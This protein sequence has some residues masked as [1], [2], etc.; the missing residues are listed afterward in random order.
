MARK[1][2]VSKGY[3]KQTT[4]KPYLSKRDIIVLCVLVAAVAVGA[5]FLFR[6]DDGAL[7]VKDGAVVAGGDNWL[8]VDG[9]NVRGRARY[10]RLG[11]IGEIDGYS[12]EKG[13]L[14][15]DAN[16][17]EYAFTPAEGDGA[18]ITVTASHTA[19]AALAKYANALFTGVEG[20]EVGQQQSAELAGRPVEYFVYATSPQAEDAD[21]EAEADKAA[22]GEA[23]D[24]ADEAAT[25]EADAAADGEAEADAQAGYTRTVNGYVDAAHDSCVVIHV[26]S[27]ADTAEGCMTDE[28]LV[29]ALE[30]AVAAVALDSAE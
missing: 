26:E 15:T 4:K 12:R 21:G 27:D 19:A 8:I 30:Q 7:K 23:G 14:S 9:S 17:P 22:E 2:A 16:V 29:A 5:F 28:Q 10:F 24:A 18:K 11:E 13:A 25:G 1:S 20:T 6:Y 3:R